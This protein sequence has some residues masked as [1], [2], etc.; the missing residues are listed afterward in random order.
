MP[1]NVSG[2][3]KEAVALKLTMEIKASEH[4]DTDHRPDRAWF[5]KTYAQCLRVVNDPNLLR[6]ILEDRN[7]HIE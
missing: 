1:T 4:P 2:D 6:S 5:L 3:S 7:L